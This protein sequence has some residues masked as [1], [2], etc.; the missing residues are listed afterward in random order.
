M[1]L[2]AIS[3]LVV[4]NGITSTE[5]I[6]LVAT[7]PPNSSF[8]KSVQLNGGVSVRSQVRITETLQQISAQNVKGST[9]F[10]KLFLRSF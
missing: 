10:K 1:R 4:E 7:I 2:I 8:I 9:S 3:A 6:L 5:N